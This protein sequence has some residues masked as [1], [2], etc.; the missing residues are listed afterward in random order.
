MLWLDAHEVKRILSK[1]LLALSALA[2]LGSVLLSVVS[3]HPSFAHELDIEPPDL[4]FHPYHFETENGT[5]VDT[6]PINLI[7]LGDLD[8]TLEHYREYFPRAS[9]R[10]GTAFQF[11]DHGAVD[12]QDDQLMDGTFFNQLHVR[13]ER[14]HDPD[15]TLGIYTLASSHRDVRAR[16]CLPFRGIPK[17]KG[18]EFDQT[19]DVI[20]DAFRAGGHTVRFVDIGNDASLDQCDG[21][22]TTGD[23]RAAII[24]LGGFIYA[25]SFA[26][27]E[28]FQVDLTTGDTTQI[29]TLGFAA[30]DMVLDSDGILYIGGVTTGVKRIDTNTNAVLPDVGTNICGPEGPSLNELDGDIYFN[31]RL[32]PCDHSGVWKI[33]RGTAATAVQV[34]PAH[35]G[36][37]EGTALLP[38]GLV[39][40]H[41]F[42]ADSTGGRIMRSSAVDL[43]LNRPP[44]PFIT[45]LTVPVGLAIDSQGRL[46]VSEA[47]LGNIRRYD[48]SGTF[49]DIFASGLSV[50]LFLEFDAAD[51][52]YVA[53]NG[54]GRLTKITP[55]GSQTVLTIVNQIVGLAISP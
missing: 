8:T 33:S 5:R 37:G 25:S 31:T 1:R 24:S 50:P 46:Y 36:W 20:A 48:S 12:D 35:S 52:L 9:R 22:S 26:N 27:G 42:S 10:F 28:I 55:D 34:M 51:N 2:V 43:L 18:V 16:G 53:E 47:G 23:G 17:H 13:F 40:S 44:S 38:F 45:G 19:R 49:L 54:T 15:P 32:T 39:I 7:F 3:W 14:G 11:E 29:A 30:E 21:T 41:L 4:S 6:G